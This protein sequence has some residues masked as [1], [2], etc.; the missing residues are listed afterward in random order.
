ML[1]PDAWVH[2]SFPH[3]GKARHGWAICASCLFHDAAAP[4]GRFLAG[5]QG[6]YDCRRRHTPLEK[7]EARSVDYPYF[8]RPGQLRN[9]PDHHPSQQSL[10]SFRHGDDLNT[11]ERRQSDTRW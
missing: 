6:Q 3:D 1:P 10:P 4:Q 8:C 9:I 11:S 7:F 5:L 2:D